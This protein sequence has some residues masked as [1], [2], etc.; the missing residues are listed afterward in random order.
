MARLCLDFTTVVF[1]FRQVEEFV[2]VN[3]RGR[4]EREK[5]FRASVSQSEILFKLIIA[6]RKAIQGRILAVDF[7]MNN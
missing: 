2:L 7:E 1:T 6:F 3:A 5:G 4:V